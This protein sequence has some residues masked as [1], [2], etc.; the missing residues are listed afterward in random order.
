MHVSTSHPCAMPS[1]MYMHTS[2]DRSH[3]IFTYDQESSPYA[4]TSDDEFIFTC[5]FNSTM[6]TFV[7]GED[8]DGEW[9]AWREQFVV[10]RGCDVCLMLYACLHMIMHHHV[11]MMLMHR[12]TYFVCHM[13]MHSLASRL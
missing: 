2:L 12:V 8:D 9:C 11:I 6:M 1:Y 10:V 3:R 13:H 7:T 4:R 5:L